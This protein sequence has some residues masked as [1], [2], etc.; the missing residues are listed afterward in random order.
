MSDREGLAVTSARRA[1]H[2]G[3]D[4]CFGEVVFRRHNEVKVAESSDFGM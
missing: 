3:V 1:R 2:E 4:C